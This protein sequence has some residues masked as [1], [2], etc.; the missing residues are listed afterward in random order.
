M[1]DKTD[2]LNKLKPDTDDPKNEATSKDS[3]WE[4]AQWNYD[5]ISVKDLMTD[6][7]GVSADVALGKSTLGMMENLS[8]DK[9]I[10]EPLRAGI[11]AQSDAARS[12]LNYIREVG[13]RE[14][15]G[16]QYV[17]V[18]T[19]E[20]LKNGKMAK[21]TLPLLTLVPIPS[22]AIKEMSYTFKVKIDTS[23]SVN[24]VSGIQ[25]NSAAWF[26]DK[27]ADM[28]EENKAED[29]GKL[30][31]AGKEEAGK[32]EDAKPATNK[33]ETDEKDEPT[34]KTE[35][36]GKAGES[37]K[38]AAGKDKAE[39]TKEG[40]TTKA[41]SSTS[42]DESIKVSA[43]GTG[44][45]PSKT[46]DSKKAPT[47]DLNKTSDIAKGKQAI[48]SSI[49][50]QVGFGASY[51]TK[52]DSRATLDSKYSIETNMDITITAGAD[53]SLPGGIAK[54]LQVL[55]DSVEI[56][57]ANGTL[58]VSANQLSLNKG[59]AVAS[60]SYKNADGFYQT[61]AISCD[62]HNGLIALDN[63][64]SKQLIFSKPGTYIFSAGRRKEVIVVTD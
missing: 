38:S 10:G 5:D 41:E 39:A 6:L 37:E 16:K 22:L 31:G 29:A 34:G 33:E 21:M 23:S 27:P 13:I 55:N 45:T 20:F 32:K 14:K 15:N 36:D 18:V 24:L 42:K 50:P 47:L 1:E 58:T 63:V 25:G 40:T 11:K 52:K 59:K 3:I 28:K 26:G 49:K 12:T 57:D 44:N 35:A 53:D 19:F 54:M 9:L 60:V 30:A 8:F 64:D 17:A 51:S 4:N 61:S 62:N 2:F 7:K 56:I 43:A 46:D 48:I